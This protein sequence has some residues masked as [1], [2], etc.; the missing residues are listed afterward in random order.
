M[1]AMTTSSALSALADASPWPECL[2]STNSGPS[3]EAASASYCSSRPSTNFTVMGTA[4]GTHP[5][6]CSPEHSSVSSCKNAACNF[7]SWPAQDQDFFAW[8]QRL[9]LMLVKVKR[10]L[11]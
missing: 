9:A 3:M 4:V 5:D 10:Q 6:E 8:L 2:Y 7:L 1:R 11:S